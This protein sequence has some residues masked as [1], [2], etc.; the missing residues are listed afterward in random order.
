MK[1]ADYARLILLAAIWGA[2]F[3]FMR[4]AA[5]ALGAINTAFFRVLFGFIGLGCILFVTR[6]KITFQGKVV[7]SLLLGVINSGIPFLMYSFAA[8]LLPAGYS[9]ILNATTPLMGAL[10]GF[11]VF[12]EKLSVKKWAGV[13]IGLL[14]IVLI[15]ATDQISSLNETIWGIVACLIA[16]SCYGVAGY[17]AR[18]WIAEKGG[19]EPKIVAFGSQMG[20][21]LFLLPFFGYS[22]AF[23]PVAQWSMTEVWASLLALGFVCTALAYILYFKLLNDIGPLRTLSVTFLIPPFGILWS[24]IV[25]G[26]QLNN[27]FYYGGAIVAIAIWLI[28]SPPKKRALKATTS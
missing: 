2:S 23:N 19:L 3:L 14:G 4:I 13:V 15:T 8:R 21:S 17:L 6:T 16:T 1:T 10:I 11:C 24:Y 9:A 25:L 27:T 5:P 7:A 26:E 12:G 18:R 28:V 20:A 22:L